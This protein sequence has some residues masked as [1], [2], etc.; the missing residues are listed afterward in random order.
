MRNGDLEML[1]HRNKNLKKIRGDQTS[2][3]DTLYDVYGLIDG[4]YI[5]GYILYARHKQANESERIYFTF[6]KYVKK[7]R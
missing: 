6:E 3:N 2:F 4:D 7:G 5:R 1:N